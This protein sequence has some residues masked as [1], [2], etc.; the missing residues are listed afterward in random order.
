VR[1]LACPECRTQYDATGVVEETIACRCGAAIENRDL[2]AIDVPVTRCSACGAIAAENARAC[3]YCG[4]EIVWK[5]PPGDLVCPECYARNPDASRFCM[6]CGVE[7]RPRPVGDVGAS[8]VE[9]IRCFVPMTPR[10]VADIAIQQCPKCSSLWVPG[11]ALDDLVRRVNE[12][13]LTA[14]KTGAGRDARVAGGNPVEQGVHYRRCPACDELMG[15]TNFRRVSGVVI[16]RCPK[17][18][19][20]L[21]ADEL[22]EIAGFVASGGLARA[23]EADA[24]EAARTGNRPGGG[25]ADAAFHRV[26][27]EHGQAGPAWARIEKLFGKLM[28]NP[29]RIV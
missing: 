18:G 3:E 8:L 26:L 19:T 7:F 12:A 5:G 24:H 6:G 25:R 2:P 20:W 16:D 13:A 9:C 11:D 29:K 14:T 21:D 15:R 22:E 27:A 17:H 28:M 1:L 10:D 23:A 4:A